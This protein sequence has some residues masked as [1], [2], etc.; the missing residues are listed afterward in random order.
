MAEPDELAE[1]MFKAKSKML[2]SLSAH[3]LIRGDNKTFCFKAVN[4]ETKISFGVI[5]TVDFEAVMKQKDALLFEL[6]AYR[7]EEAV[8]FSFLAVVDIV[9]LRSTLLLCGAGEERLACEAFGHAASSEHTL[10]LGALVSR[11]KDFI[12]PLSTLLQSGWQL[13]KVGI[14]FIYTYILSH[15]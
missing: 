11:K 13:P 1:Q 9:N 6:R 3:G 8:N 4:S 10:N 5:E 7:H 15:H 12:P 2:L 14:F